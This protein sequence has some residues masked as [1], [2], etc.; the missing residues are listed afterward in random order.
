[1]YKPARIDFTLAQVK[2]AINGLPIRVAASQ[3]G[4]GDKVIFLHPSQHRVVSK[5]GMSGKGCVVQL[6]PAEILTTVESDMDGTG[7]F[8]DL[9]KNLKT[10]YSWAKRNIIDTDFYQKNVKPLARQAIDTGISALAG[11]APQAVPIATAVRDKLSKE[12]GAF[13]IPK[14]RRRVKRSENVLMGGSFR[15]N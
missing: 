6:S 9:W 1:M 15:L 10:G 5:A 3:I 12:T 11:Y 14:T 7:L 13:G 4:N 8:G 2:K